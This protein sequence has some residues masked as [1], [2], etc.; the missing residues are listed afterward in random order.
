M[1]AVA[2][3]LGVQLEKIGH[4]RI[5]DNREGLGIKH[6]YRAMRLVNLSTTIAVALMALMLWRAS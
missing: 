4:Y 3:A 6:I 2:G 1:A 5:G